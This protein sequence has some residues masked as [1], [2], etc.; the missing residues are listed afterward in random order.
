MKKCLLAF[1]FL[2][3]SCIFVFS[4]G[5]KPKVIKYEAPIYPPV[6]RAVRATGEITV[7]VVINKV[8]K[9]TLSKAETGLPLLKQTSENAAKKW[10]F[11]AD[12]SIE[13]REAKLTFR[14]LPETKARKDKIIF[15]KP[16]V[17]EIEPALLKIST[18]SSY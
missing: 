4:Q 17:L 13:A 12:K 3:L 5:I 9:V 2:F 14:F 16:Y 11:N 1:C 7:N 10:R 8:G 18:Y 15:K 6:A